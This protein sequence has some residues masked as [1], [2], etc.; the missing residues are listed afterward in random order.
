MAAVLCW[1]CSDNDAAEGGAVQ[2][3]DRRALTIVA[4]EEPWQGETV[5]VTRSGETLTA[6]KA[7]N[8]GFGLFCSDLSMTNTKV[9]WEDDAW[10]YGNKLLW[11]GL[12]SASSSVDFYAY[13]PYVSTASLT[14]TPSE[15]I[16]AL[17][18]ASVTF[19]PALRNTI[20]L[21]WA[22]GTVNTTT[23]VVTFNFQHA[24]GKLSFGHIT[25][26]YGRTITLTNIALSGTRYTTGT[27][28]LSDGTWTG[29]ASSPAND[30]DDCSL[31]VAAGESKLIVDMPAILQIPGQSVTV[32]FT[33]TSADYGTETV[34]SPSITF[35]QGTD[36]TV[37][38][39][40]G[41]NHEVKIE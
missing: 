8:D 18:S 37:N 23:G 17:S 36:K 1:A 3:D 13:A 39:T 32:T 11:P 4:S 5:T 28:S 41:M 2:P 26:N 35:E 14:P 20:D 15:G 19:S 29:I 7:S 34:T 16:T 24:L 21:L 31:E 33:I 30:G 22:K 38:L 9:V 6:L 12:T 27:L 40:V 25:N 10:N